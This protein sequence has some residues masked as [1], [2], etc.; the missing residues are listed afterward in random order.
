[1]PTNVNA[2]T[3]MFEPRFFQGTT[4]KDKATGITINRGDICNIDTGTA[5]DSYRTC[6][7]SGIGPFVWA[8]QTVL[9]AAAKPTFSAIDYPCEVYVKCD[10]AIE[11]GSVV[12]TSATTAGRVMAGA[13]TLA[14][15]PRRVGI[16]LRKPGQGDSTNPLAAAADGDVIIIWFEPMAGSPGA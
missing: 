14:T 4:P 13:G 8:E 2:I 15:N 1:M 5:P 6:P 7:T 12:Q 11:V 10:G 3:G 16:F 9:A